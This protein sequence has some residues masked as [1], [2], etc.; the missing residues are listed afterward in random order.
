MHYMR[1]FE[2]KANP[3]QRYFFMTTLNSPAVIVEQYCE[4]VCMWN[5]FPFRWGAV[6]PSDGT[7]LTRPLRTPLISTAR[8]EEA[9]SGLGLVLPWLR[10]GCLM[11]RGVV[12]TGSFFASICGVGSSTHWRRHQSRRKVVDP[13]RGCIHYSME[14]RRSVHELVHGYL[15]DNRSK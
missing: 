8:R 5:I 6:I 11:T 15:S 3:V 12:C 14:T 1:C 9:T 10:D 4:W 13:F 7:K 2:F